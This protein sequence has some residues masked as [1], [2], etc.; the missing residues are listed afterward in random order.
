M[1]GSTTAPARDGIAEAAVRPVR[2]LLANRV[3]PRI[4]HR[5]TGDG[6]AFVSQ[7][8]ARWCAVISSGGLAAAIA[9]PAVH[10]Q[11]LLSGRLLGQRQAGGTEVIPFSGVLGVL[12][13]AGPDAEA[14]AFRT[15][16]TEPAGW[17]RFSTDAGSHTLV[18]AGPHH[19]LRPIVLNQVVLERGERMDSLRPTARFDFAVFDESGWDPAPASS[20]YQPFVARGTSLTHVGFRLAHDGV[21]GAGAGAQD[22]VVSIH[23]RA[24]GPPPTWPAVG[25]VATVLGVDCG[26]AKNPMWYAGWDSGQ[27]PLNPG[28]V[29]AVRLAAAAAGGR[30]QTFWRTNDSAAAGLYRETPEGT[31][32]VARDL[33]LA[34][35]TDGDGVLVPYNKK[36]QRTFTE[37]A[38]FDARWSQTYVAR[39]RSVAAV[40]LYAAV[41]GAQ[42]P[43]NRQRVLVRLRRGGPDGP[44]SGMAKIGIGSGN[45]TG[46]ASWGAFGVAFA[47]GEAPVTPGETYAVEFTSL[48]G[49]ATLEGYINIKQAVSDGRAGF[50]PYRKAPPDDHAAGT[51]FKGGITPMPFDLDLQILEYEFAGSET[52]PVLAEPNL[53]RNGE[54]TEFS[55]MPAAELELPGPLPGQAGYGP[56]GRAVGGAAAG[57]RFLPANAA[58]RLA[59]FREPDGMADRFFA[60]L[61]SPGGVPL[62]AVLVQRVGGLSR[63][64]TY[65]LRGMVRASWPVDFEHQGQVGLDPTG[66]D[67]NSAAASIRWL[68]LPP[69]HGEFLAFKSAPTRPVADTISVWLRAKSS[70]QGDPYAPFH[71]DF[72]DLRLQRLRTEPPAPGGE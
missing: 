21:D 49:P 24:E 1:S 32:W 11:A 58:S 62:D 39:G 23:R 50:N 22:L 36:V 54:F 28:E 13:A 9:I 4:R 38:G 27:V 71:V 42:P 64:E 43:L 37:F 10:P 40:I 25:P 44:V 34:V 53:L 60:R 17:F 48:E 72:G 67:T 63:M 6:R 61:A 12:S 2:E 14:R 56:T 69:R 47:P 41:G 33:W 55:P 45:Y 30:F 59:I 20:Y 66:Q 65:C 70:W 52:G 16:E 3:D 29:Y 15:W 57:W 51:A 35:G 19:F 46:D 18:F 7:I 31:G 8:R 5:E 68:T 26:G